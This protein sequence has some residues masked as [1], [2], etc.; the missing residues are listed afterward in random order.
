MTGRSPHETPRY[1]IRRGRAQDLVRLAEAERSAAVTY[2]AA[3]G[4]PA[5]IP[6]AMAADALEACLAAGLLWV[7]TDRRDVP[8][9]F[10]AAEVVDGHLF[11]K[12]MSVEREHQRAG[13]GRRL[14][15]AA[16]DHARQAA[17]GALAL[18]TDR[19]IPFN[20]PFYERLGFRAVAADH[21]TPGLR[22]RLADE[23][24]GGFDPQR[25]ILMTKPVAA[26]QPSA[27][28]LYRERI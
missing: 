17:C 11:V 7:A 1:A 12:E 16:E 10:L 14:M 28:P 27:T 3:L 9:G 26:L 15:Q 5:E 24:A 21:A 23:I 18:T 2:F 6:E 8:V 22:R 20:G 25:R 13:L 19:L 4:S